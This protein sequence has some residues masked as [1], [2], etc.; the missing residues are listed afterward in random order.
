[1]A[2]RTHPHSQVSHSWSPHHTVATVADHTLLTVFV[3]LHV[4]NVTGSVCVCDIKIYVAPILLLKVFTHSQFLDFVGSVNT[5]IGMYPRG[6]F[7]LI[8]RPHHQVPDF[9]AVFPVR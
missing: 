1:M 2:I 3:L 5:F 6:F 7:N 4:V 9:I 8:I